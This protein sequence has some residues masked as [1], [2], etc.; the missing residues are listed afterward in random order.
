MGQSLAFLIQEGRSYNLQYIQIRKPSI[1]FLSSFFPSFLLSFLLYVL[2]VTPQFRQSVVSETHQEE[3]TLPDLPCSKPDPRNRS[4][5]VCDPTEKW[6]LRQL[7]I[8]QRHFVLST[9]KYLLAIA[10]VRGDL[11]ISLKFHKLDLLPSPFL[12]PPSLGL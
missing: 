4:L 9:T 7:T 2:F 10:E 8:L 12:S 11:E 5:S 3:S 6:R 1:A